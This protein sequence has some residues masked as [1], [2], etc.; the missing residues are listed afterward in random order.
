MTGS[1][2][3]RL[4]DMLDP[5]STSKSAH[6]YVEER[7]SLSLQVV[8]SSRSVAPVCDFGSKLLPQQPSPRCDGNFLHCTVSSIWSPSF[9][10]TR[11]HHSSRFFTPRSSGH[12][13][14]KSG[15]NQED[16]ADAS[17]HA[18]YAAVGKGKRLLRSTSRRK[19]N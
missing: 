18:V 9:T 2:I 14:Q 10:H 13:T 17:K 7:I 6:D 3:L 5:S 19:K 11:Q 8:E 12:V 16:S 1:A 4:P 15:K